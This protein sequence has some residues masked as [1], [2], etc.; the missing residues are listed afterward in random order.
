ML[1]HY[2]HVCKQVCKFQFPTHFDLPIG[3]YWK[4]FPWFYLF[5][6]FIVGH[7]S[8]LLVL[9]FLYFFFLVLFNQFFFLLIV[10]FVGFFSFNEC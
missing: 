4:F 8:Y 1:K 2:T 5:V 10:L 9:F 3:L 7:F 6:I